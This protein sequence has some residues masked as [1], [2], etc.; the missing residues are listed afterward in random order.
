ML[1]NIK[2]PVA[3]D[4]PRPVPNFPEIRATWTEIIPVSFPIAPR[5]CSGMFHICWTPFNGSYNL[6]KIPR[7]DAFQKTV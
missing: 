4:L 6:N 1:Y 5:N 2:I 3:S 7:P